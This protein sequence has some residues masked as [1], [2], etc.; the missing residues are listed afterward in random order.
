VSQDEVAHAVGALIAA[1]RLCV[2]WPSLWLESAPVRGAYIVRFDLMARD[3][4]EDSATGGEQRMN[5]FVTAGFMTKQPR[6]NRAAVY[7]L[8]PQGAAAL[9]GGGSDGRPYQFCGLTSE[10]L[11]EVTR[12]E[13]GQFPCGNLRAHF[14]F[15]ADGWPSW[16]STPDLRSRI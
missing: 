10:H 14:T 7:T 9:Q 8:T 15:V 2:N 3:W 1:R 5:D 16:A 11:V 4:G 13:W 6:G 12:L